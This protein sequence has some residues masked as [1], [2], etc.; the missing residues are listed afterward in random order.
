ME[1]TQSIGYCIYLQRHFI[2]FISRIF[3]VDPQ[4]IV[5]SDMQ[6]AEMFKMSL[7]RDAAK[8]KL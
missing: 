4:G 6:I 3:C 7:F 1:F 5:Y 8:E 2:T